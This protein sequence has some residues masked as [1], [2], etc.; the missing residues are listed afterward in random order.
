MTRR[1]SEDI[2]A[3]ITKLFLA[4]AAELHAFACTLPGVDEDRAGYLV[5]ESFQAAALSWT[6]L[7]GCDIDERRDWLCKVIKY[8]SISQW[9]RDK[10]L[11]TRSSPPQT[12]L[13]T[14]PA[15]NQALSAADLARCWSLVREMPPERQQVAFLRW[16]EDWTSEEIA[17]WLGISQEAVRA[18]LTVANDELIA[19][20]DADVPFI[21][22]P[23]I[24]ERG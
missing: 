18:H 11:I 13:F 2:A 10:K 3:E 6:E 15:A 5:K 17:G 22:D 24:D 12:S 21:G 20:V 8:K 14:D 16:S 4:A 23:E 19:Q 1:I 9:R 7:A